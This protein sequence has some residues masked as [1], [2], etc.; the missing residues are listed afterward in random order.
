M[1]ELEQ[2]GL[3]V[4]GEEVTEEETI[5]PKSRINK[6]LLF[7]QIGIIIFTF[8]NYSFIHMVRQSWSV[9]KDKIEADLDI[10]SNT[11]GVFDALFLGFYSAGLVING[12]LGDRYNLKLV[13]GLG[14]ICTGCCSAC[15]N[16]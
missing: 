3:L 7:Y 5:S 15:V 2:R 14:L 9:S 4:A 8:F 6:R 10:S 11:L 1:S 13:I 16:N 12:Y